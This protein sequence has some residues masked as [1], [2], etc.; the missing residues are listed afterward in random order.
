MK[1]FPAIFAACIA[2]S[3]ASF[4]QNTTVKQTKEPR[5]GVKKVTSARDTPPAS[6]TPGPA[7]RPQVKKLLESTPAYRGQK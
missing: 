1:K 2:I 6:S 7:V 5:V 4:A 3:L